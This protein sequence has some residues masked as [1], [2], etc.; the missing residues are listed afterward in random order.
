MN[1]DFKRVSFLKAL[2][3]LTISILTKDLVPQNNFSLKLNIY[4]KGLDY[5]KSDDH[6]NLKS[7]LKD[8]KK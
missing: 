7:E 5:I 8:L 1:N 4:F 2:N 3:T 6:G